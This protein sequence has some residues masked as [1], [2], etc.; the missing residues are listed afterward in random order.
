MKQKFPTYEELV[1]LVNEILANAVDKETGKKETLTLRQIFYKLV[2][3]HAID[4]TTSNYKLL[5]AKL[6]LARERGDVDDRRIEDR[7]RETVGGDCSL[8]DPEEYYQDHETAFR[9]SWEHYSRPFWLDQQN[10]VE[11]WCFHPKTPVVTTRGVRPIELIQVGERVLTKPGTFEIVSSVMERNYSGKI[12]CINATGCLPIKTTPDHL[13]FVSKRICAPSYRGARRKISSPEF[14]QAGNVEKFDYLAIPRI[15]ETEDVKSITMVGGPHAIDLKDILFDEQFCHVIGL[16]LSEGNITT[17]QR[18]V[19]FTFDNQKPEYPKIIKD[20]GSRLGAV[21]YFVDG[22]GARVAFIARTALANWLK[23]NFGNGAYNKYFPEWCMHLPQPK[24]LE[25]LKYYFLGDGNFSDVTRRSISVSSKSISLIIQTQLILARCGISC[26]IRTSN[27]YKGVTYLLTITGASLDLVSSLWNIYPFP[28]R[29]TKNISYNHSRIDDNYMYSPIR[30]ITEET[31][32][33]KVYNIEVDG[34][35]TYCLPCVVHNCEKNTLVRII[36]SVASQ[37][38]VMT[39]VGRGYSSYS[40]INDAV[41]RIQRV[42]DFEGESPRKPRILY[43][44]D[45]DPSG[46]DM[47]RDLE[48]RLRKYGLNSVE[49]QIVEKIAVTPEQIREYGLPTI[50]IDPAKQKRDSRSSKFINEF[51]ED[52]VE[53]DAFDI[54]QLKLIVK[55][56][57]ES[58]IDG[59]AW[60]FHQDESEREREE[61]R[62]KIEQHFAR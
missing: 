44:G 61:L 47:V 25:I 35:H 45:H 49:T 10:Y 46:S 48:A 37:Y 60:N 20:F 4:N 34:T 55:T 23:E 50:P 17:N 56:G 54:E 14:I 27:D 21:A 26:T 62:Q 38:N 53:I 36:S 13:F 28:D 11:C 41:Q 1:K 30:A 43:L 15:Q 24:Q 22:Q 29:K 39:C 59:D 3:I 7:A 58:L 32:S 42:C 12:I 8:R 40:Y 6:V 51:G 33:G 5:S 18:A 31:Y 9:R 52:T 16:Y 2:V 57:I 19:Q